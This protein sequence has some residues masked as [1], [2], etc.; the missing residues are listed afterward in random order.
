MFAYIRDPAEI[1]RRSFEIIA[2]EA[3]LATLPGEMAAL[4]A[5]VVHASGMPD[6]LRDLA[7]SDGAASKG[8]DA[9][10]A[11]AAVLCDVRMVAAGLIAARLARRMLCMW[12]S[13]SPAPPTSRERRGRRAAQLGWSA[14][15]TVSRAQSW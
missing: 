9:L 3:D 13:N 12:P 10:A 1:T 2:A 14:C 6:L 4:A 15:A 7:F 11:G 8:R 5:R